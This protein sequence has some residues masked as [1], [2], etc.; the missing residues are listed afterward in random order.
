MFIVQTSMFTGHAWMFVLRAWMFGFL[1]R[2]IA[3]K[4][5]TLT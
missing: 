1:A 5:N 4:Q 2:I 3:S